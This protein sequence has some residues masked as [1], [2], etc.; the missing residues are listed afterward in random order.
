MNKKVANPM[1]KAERLIGAL[2]KHPDYA[3]LAS[4]EG[5]FDM[6]VDALADMMHVCDMMPYDFKKIGR[7]HV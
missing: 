2:R 5:P 4:V 1:T 6:L 7:A 3:R